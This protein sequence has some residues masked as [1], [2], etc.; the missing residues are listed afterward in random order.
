MRTLSLGYSP[1]PND[2]FIF[3]SLVHGKLPDMRGLEFKEVLDD[4]EALNAMAR[5]SELDVTKVSYGAVAGLLDE[6]CLLRSGGAL[7]RGCGPLVVAKQACRM[8]DLK[9]KRIAIPGE[10]TTAFLLLRLYDPALGEGVV[11]MLFSDIMSAVQKGEVDAGLIIHESRFTY[12]EYGLVEVEDLGRW[13]EHETGKPIP[14]GGIV[15][16]RAL[17]EE[18][19]HNVNDLIR[20]SVRYAFDHRDEPM[21]YIRRHSQEL[22]DEVVASHIGLYVNDYSLDMGEVGVEA[23]KTLME[24]AVER[25][26]ISKPPKT[27]FLES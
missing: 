23:V 7:G 9:G 27:L 15:A 17:G 26:I 11:P 18:T 10:N 25:G 20:E 1:C 8:E 21:Q 3:Y 14:L 6:Y 19:I 24:I 12:P 22:S 16:R 2:T 4:V 5:R 13:W